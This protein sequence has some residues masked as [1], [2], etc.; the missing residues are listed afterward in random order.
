M[1]LVNG[2][3]FQLS[4]PLNFI[5]SVYREL[6]QSLV[7][8][9]E[10]FRLRR[11]VPAIA[12]RPNARELRIDWRTRAGA[13]AGATVPDIEDFNTG[14]GSAG[15]DGDDVDVGSGVGVGAISFQDVQFG[16]PRGDRQILRGLSLDIPPGKV[17]AVVG[18]SGCG[19]STLLR[20]L[21]RFFDLNGNSNSDDQQDFTTDNKNS[22]SVQIDGVDVR[23]YTLESLRKNIAVVPQDTVLFNG[24]LGYNIRYGNL[25]ASE[26]Q[27]RDAAERVR[28]GPLLR[29]L[30]DGLNTQV[31]ERGLK[32]S[33]GEKQRVAIARAMLKDCP[34]LLCDEPTSALD[35]VTEFEV[36]CCALCV[37]LVENLRYVIPLYHPVTLPSSP[38]CAFPCVPSPC[39]FLYVTSSATPYTFPLFFSHTSHTRRPSIPPSSHTNLLSFFLCSLLVLSC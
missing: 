15:F 5:G 26:E 11:V 3:L 37:V 36:R 32:L 21:Y 38:F 9:T 14:T 4:I 28:L 7:D 12:D 25:D 30:P 23:D 33:G 8:M 22:G 16:Y 27:V 17:V 18:G 39:M 29:Q 13:T 35:S 31:G 10:M 19:K 1:V 6:S 2:L 34:I 20:L 24:T